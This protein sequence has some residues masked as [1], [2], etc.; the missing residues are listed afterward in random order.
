MS[1]YEYA[2]ANGYHLLVSASAIEKHVDQQ[3]DKKLTDVTY[4]TATRTPSTDCRT[5]SPT[6]P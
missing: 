1:K 4:N 5:A 3:P 2:L 6:R